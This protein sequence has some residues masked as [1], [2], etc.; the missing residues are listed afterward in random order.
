MIPVTLPAAITLG[1]IFSFITKKILKEEAE[2]FHHRLLGFF[3]IYIIC[4][5]VP[6]GMFF[7][8]GWPSWEMMYLTGWLENAFDRPLV[9]GFHVAYYVLMILLANTGFILGHYLIR[10]EKE[11]FVI[12]GLVSGAL[13]T[14]VAILLRLNV[15]FTI[16]T[17]AEIQQNRGASFVEGP[18][19]I[20]WII[21]MSYMALTTVAAILIMRRRAKKGF[22]RV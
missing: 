21:I 19:F 5:F 9:A 15:F 1:F 20:G 3:N 6:A 17:Y 22:Q 11:T 13:V 16:G 7:L 4:G 2:L 18:F 8:T 14:I 12:I 10:K